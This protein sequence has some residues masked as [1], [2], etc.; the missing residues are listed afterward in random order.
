MTPELVP[1]PSISVRSW[2][3]VFSRSSLPPKLAPLE[4]ARPTASISSINTIE[5]AFSLAFLKRSR[6][7]LAPTPTNISTKSEPLMEK[8][9]T[10]AS[11]ATALAN[12]VLPVPGGPTRRAPLG[13]LPPSSVY[14]AGFFK[15]STISCTSC[16]APS[17]PATS[18]K[19]T[20]TALSLSYS[21]ALL[22]PTEKMPP[23]APPPAPRSMN[24]QNPIRS[25]MGKR[26][27]RMLKKMEL[28]SS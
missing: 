23:P 28:F 13:I 8:K 19:R 7:R 27:E 21:L 10:A 18:L 4:R 11:P 15:K 12:R 16:L 26:P 20:C 25:M 14:L 9:G 6:T 22:L 2:L 3:S 1:K 17:W 5:G 24:H